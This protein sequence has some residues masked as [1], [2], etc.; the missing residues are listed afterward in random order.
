MS[1]LPPQTRAADVPVLECLMY[2]APVDGRKTAM[3]VF[4]SPSK[5]P[6]TAMSPTPP[7]RADKDTPEVARIYQVPVDGR[8]TAMSVRPSPS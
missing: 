3:S 7:Q 1:P 4:P 5:S 6:G 8:K 2:Q